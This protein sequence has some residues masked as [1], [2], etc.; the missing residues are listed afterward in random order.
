MAVAGNQVTVDRLREL[1]A[2]VLHVDVTQVTEDALFY[3]DLEVDSLHKTEISERVER[4]FH[5]RIDA[6]DWAGMRTIADVMT[7]LRDKRVV[8]DE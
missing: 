4:E 1:V 7:L 2:T 6:E 5:V 8:T 3:E